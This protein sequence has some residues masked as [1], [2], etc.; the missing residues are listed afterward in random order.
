MWR[1]RNLS[2]QQSVPDSIRAAARS[3]ARTLFGIKLSPA[4]MATPTDSG[5]STDV[6][7]RTEQFYL[8]VS[9][10]LGKPKPIIQMKVSS[11][12]GKM[13]GPRL[14][15]QDMDL[16]F[17]LMFLQLAFQHHL[18]PKTEGEVKELHAGYEKWYEDQH[19]PF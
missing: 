7:V 16:E 15:T 19:S 17:M 12:G 18:F 10:V 13:S 4:R 2:L 3:L 1:L 9:L 6:S 11:G 14:P 8:A 5:L